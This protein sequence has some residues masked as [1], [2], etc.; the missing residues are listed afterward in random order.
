V[1][2]DGA[3]VVQREDGERMVITWGDVHIDD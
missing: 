3:L 2:E 1:A